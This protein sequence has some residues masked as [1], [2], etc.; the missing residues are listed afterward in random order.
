MA[1]ARFQRVAQLWNWLPPFRG[2]AEEEG[3]HLA[4][5]T[6][7][8]S[9]SALSRTVKLL[10]HAVGAPLFVREANGLR[11]TP[12]GSD[13]LAATRDAMRLVDDCIDRHRQSR[14][15]RSLPITIGTTSELVAVACAALE[16][17]RERPLCIRGTR[18]TT[19]VEDLLHGHLD[20]ALSATEVHADAIVCE[21][22]GG[23]RFGL[24]ATPSHPLAARAGC[25]DLAELAAEHV[26][27]PT[28]LEG[29]AP[30]VIVAT[31][32]APSVLRALC[33]SASAIAVL[34]DA[35]SARENGLVRLGDARCGIMIH[36]VARRS[37]D[38]SSP[39]SED[40][41]EIVELLRRF[42]M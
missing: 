36:A 4:A 35:V 8:V 28:G 33:E 42:L 10:E 18:E 5:A 19:L 37:V 34:P 30:G 26:V 29:E 23:I 6:L 25:V 15:E 7:G 12:F 17:T 9:P 21:L 24:Y 3:I 40:I 38:P 41:R 20:L 13:L 27:V 39:T 11:L 1:T 32:D 16:P 31:A 2:V 22:V 14:S